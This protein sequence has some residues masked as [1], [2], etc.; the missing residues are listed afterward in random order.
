MII[1]A[2]NHKTS[3]SIDNIADDAPCT[4]QDDDNDDNNF[5]DSVSS[6]DQLDKMLPQVNELPCCNESTAKL[7]PLTLTQMVASSVTTPASKSAAVT[8]SKSTGINLSD[9]SC[10]SSFPGSG[11]SVADEASTVTLPLIRP[12]EPNYSSSGLASTTKSL[13]A[14]T[15]QLSASSS[16]T[17]LASSTSSSN[18][19]HSTTNVKTVSETVLKSSP[20]SIPT[21]G[22][23]RQTV[24][25]L[26]KK[27]LTQILNTSS[28]LFQRKKQQL[29][30]STA[31]TVASGVDQKCVSFS[32]GSAVV[33]V[34]DLTTRLDK[35]SGSVSLSASAVDGGFTPAV[36][37][38]V[39]VAV[40]SRDGGCS[41]SFE[42]PVG[43]LSTAVHSAAAVDESKGNSSTDAL[44]TECI[45]VTS[46]SLDVGQPNRKSADDEVAVVALAKRRSEIEA[47]AAKCH[48]SSRSGSSASLD[49]LAVDRS[50]ASQ[51]SVNAIPSSSDKSAGSSTSSCPAPPTVLCAGDGL[52]KTRYVKTCSSPA[53]NQ[54]FDFDVSNKDR[55][56]NVCM[57][58]YLPP[59]YDKQQR[60]IKPQKDVLI[61]HVSLELMDIALNCLST[62]QGDFTETFMLTPSEFKLDIGKPQ[63]AGLSTHPGFSEQFCYG[64]ITLR[65]HY[66]WQAISAK[67]H[68]QIL[69][70][71]DGIEKL[72]TAAT[73]VQP[74]PQQHIP[75]TVGSKSNVSMQMHSGVDGIGSKNHCFTI[76]QFQ[77]ST[78]CDFCRK[79]IWLKSAF[80]CSECLKA[81]HKKCVEK[82][83][84]QTTCTRNEP[85]LGKQIAPGTKPIETDDRL[86]INEPA[87]PVLGHLETGFKGE[88]PE[89]KRHISAPDESHSDTESTVSSTRLSAAATLPRPRSSNSLQDLANRSPT[90]SIEELMSTATT[91]AALV[92]DDEL[93]L[94]Q[95][96]ERARKV[97]NSDEMVVTEA[98][99]MGKELF[100]ELEPDARKHKLD[101]IISKLQSEIDNESE[102]RAELAKQSRAT[103]DRKLKSAM[104]ARMEKSDEKLDSM[105]VLMLHYCAGL[106]HCLDQEEVERIK[107][108]EPELC[109]D[110]DGSST[111]EK[112]CSTS[113]QINSSDIGEVV[114][115]ISAEADDGI[116]IENLEEFS[117]FVEAKDKDCSGQV[118]AKEVNEQLCGEIIVAMDEVTVSRDSMVNESSSAAATEVCVTQLLSACSG[119]QQQ[120]WTVSNNED[121][122][123]SARDAADVAT[124]AI[125]TCLSN[126]QPSAENFSDV[127]VQDESVE[128]KS[129]MTGDLY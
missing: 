37:S 25:P 95:L 102:H 107:R 30:S 122:P 125:L 89:R 105:T 4:T 20:L 85:K 2:N 28:A 62:L 92:A 74:V 120:Q 53:F 13:S 11:K 6:Y 27:G 44:G 93:K 117:A 116:S 33:T 75:A 94:L 52:Q 34:A 104:E 51:T 48:Q 112:S 73:D 111:A 3:S 78:Y 72:C 61:G 83:Q 7:P 114:D 79:K 1:P 31:V 19:H 124:S 118:E 110:P 18:S 43:K 56:L 128:N 119:V 96:F 40:D 8:S 23:V 39:P 91:S 38:L 126:I 82:C 77:T 108:M 90:P 106:Q 35:G 45:Q 87:V 29:R 14:S 12:S 80:R 123:P 55:F 24:P 57:W 109:K 121:C 15:Q 101:S 76:V 100:A 58:C 60:L 47:E 113:G 10:C 99:K 42:Q 81:C 63:F 59:K 17:S 16:S 64:D 69:K 5:V 65:F 66:T 32:T 70:Q 71:H 115:S 54:K 46:A 36:S 127:I 9:N 41:S 50:V 129:M 22:G 68:K 84:L 67:A 103:A 21:K 88:E 86:S 97:Q 98:K 26:A 49:Q